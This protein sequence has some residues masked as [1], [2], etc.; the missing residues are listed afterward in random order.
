MTIPVR[1]ISTFWVVTGGDLVAPTPEAG[2]SA[3]RTQVEGSVTTAAEND[4]SDQ[5]QQAEK[6]AP[7]RH[8]LLSA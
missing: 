6:S 8:L 5:C 2:T 1:E 4:G 7:Q 3:Y